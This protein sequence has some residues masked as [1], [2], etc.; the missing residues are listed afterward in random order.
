M[1]ALL[2]EILADP[3]LTPSAFKWYREMKALAGTTGR[4]SGSTIANIVTITAGPAQE[5]GPPLVVENSHTSF[6]AYTKNGTVIVDIQTIEPPRVPSKPEPPMRKQ[7]PEVRRLL[8]EITADPP[9]TDG[10]IDLSKFRWQ[11]DLER[12]V[13]NAPSLTTGS[14]VNGVYVRISDHYTEDIPYGF[15]TTRMIVNDEPANGYVF[16]YRSDAGR[17]HVNILIR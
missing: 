9:C 17:V 3:P 16:S 12:L 6:R 5:P 4:V 14:Y 1:Q 11:A 7:N 8:N 15:S 2:E 10:R 13:G